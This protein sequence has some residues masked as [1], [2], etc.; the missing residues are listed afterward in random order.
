MWMVGK[1]GKQLE[2]KPPYH[3]SIVSFALAKTLICVGDGKDP[4]PAFFPLRPLIAP[5]S[6]PA[7]YHR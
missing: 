6:F 4:G 7:C 5:L 3:H 1:G 2:E